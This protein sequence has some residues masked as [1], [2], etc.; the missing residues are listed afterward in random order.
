MEIILGPLAPTLSKQ[1]RGKLP[2]DELAVFE[3]DHAA[4]NRL[5]TRRYLTRAQAHIA[6][7]KLV[8]RIQ[9]ELERHAGS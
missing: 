7:R 6:Q 5:S 1:L 3:R 2:D 8:K 9:K 4:I